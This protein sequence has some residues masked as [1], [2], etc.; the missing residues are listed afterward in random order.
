M[1]WNHKQRPR[2]DEKPKKNDSSRNITPTQTSALKPR[3]Y[4]QI[5]DSNPLITIENGI[6]AY[7][8]VTVAV[9]ACGLHT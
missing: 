3:V 2:S 6:S 9:T 4:A 1:L 5:N 7:Q 8:A